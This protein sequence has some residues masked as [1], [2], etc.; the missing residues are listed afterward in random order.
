MTEDEKRDLA[1]GRIIRLRQEAQE[2][3]TGAECRAKQ[4]VRG[5]RKW[6]DYFDGEGTP[7]PMSCP[8]QEELMAVDEDIKDAKAR[9]SNLQLGIVDSS[10]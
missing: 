2:D 7:L 8:S 10:R 9:L 3:L 4:L 6:I 5:L 1:R